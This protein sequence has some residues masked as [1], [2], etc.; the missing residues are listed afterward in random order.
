MSPASKL[1]LHMRAVR[2]GN[3]DSDL[4]ADIAVDDVSSTPGVCTPTCE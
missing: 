3:A 2:G 4:Q 1:Q